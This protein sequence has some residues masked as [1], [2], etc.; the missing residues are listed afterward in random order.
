MNNDIRKEYI[1]MIKDIIS[2]LAISNVKISCFTE[3][4]SDKVIIKVDTK[5]QCT[6]YSFDNLSSAL[7]FLEYWGN[8]DEKNV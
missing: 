7:L 2:Y 1:K 8:S 5:T 6:T 4:N 3:I